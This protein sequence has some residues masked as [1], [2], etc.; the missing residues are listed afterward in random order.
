MM[1]LAGE[2]TKGG[3]GNRK[4][5]LFWR[6][7]LVREEG[8]KILARTRRSHSSFLMSLRFRG[9]DVYCKSRARTNTRES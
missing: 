8:G 4:L 9:C 6:L 3:R 1:Y 2:G 7:C 5:L